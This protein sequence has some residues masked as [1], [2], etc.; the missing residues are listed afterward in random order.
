M[1]STLSQ[2]SN[3]GIKG[4]VLSVWETFFSYYLPESTEMLP[5][6]KHSKEDLV[7]LTCLW[8]RRRVF[9]L[10]YSLTFLEKLPEVK[11]IK[12]WLAIQCKWQSIYVIVKA[13][14]HKHW[15]RSWS[16]KL[17]YKRV[18]TKW[19]SEVGVISKVISA[20]ESESK[21]SEHFYFFHLCLR[22]RHLRSIYDLEKTSLLESEAEA[23]G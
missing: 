13:G 9:S 10:I 19:K 16:C 21:E 11:L 22:L 23:E 12:S 3:S 18:L 15:S 1:H 8:A 20:T 14:F 7:W 6:K 17:S 4:S 5:T 2:F